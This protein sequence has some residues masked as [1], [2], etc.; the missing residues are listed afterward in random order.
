MTELR[1][2]LR[3]G[4]T[5]NEGRVELYLNGTWGTI[6]DD[7]WGI[8]EAN[9]ICRM[10]GYSEGAWSTHCCGWYPSYSALQKIWLDDVHCVGDEQSIAE[11]RHGGWGSHNCYH[12]ED[13]GVVCK[14]TP[15][16]ASGRKSLCIFMISHDLI[17]IYIQ[18]KI[19]SDSTDMDVILTIPF[20]RW[21][22]RWIGTE[23]YPDTQP[24]RKAVWT[25]L[26]IE[27]DAFHLV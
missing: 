19:L 25:F 15:I 20:R 23:I 11:C 5:S 9:V 18:R 3:D 6:C 4:P 24:F 7:Y 8:D 1:V 12:A 22:N 14:Y 17:Y 10:L 16:P 13:V 27:K 2:R 21:H 26:P